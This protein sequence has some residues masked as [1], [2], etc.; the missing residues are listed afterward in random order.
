MAEAA[1]TYQEKAQRLNALRQELADAERELKRA[2]QATL[3]HRKGAT[4]NPRCEAIINRYTLLAA[5]AGLL[6][7][8]LDAAALTG[9]QIKLIDALAEH[10]GKNYTE[11]Q[12]KNTLVAITGGMV[13]PLAA[14]SIAGAA[15][16]VPV[17]GPV[18][19]LVTSPAA[20]AI[21]T[22]VIGHLALERFEREEAD[23]AKIPAKEPVVTAPR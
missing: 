4:S 17:V 9:L 21:S 12:G 1:T 11:E 2:R 14:P 10:F 22:R 23:V 20:A 16:V 15:A 13:A 3:E 8:F 6:P 7:T 5:V 19:S 18:V